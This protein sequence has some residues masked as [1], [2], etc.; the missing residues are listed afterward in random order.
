MQVNNLNRT[1]WLYFLYL[2]TN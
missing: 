2:T 1:L